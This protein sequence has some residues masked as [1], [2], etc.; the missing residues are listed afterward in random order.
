M[1]NYARVAPATAAAA[2]VCGGEGVEQVGIG[3]V[4]PVLVPRE[5][6]GEHRVPDRHREHRVHGLAL[7]RSATNCAAASRQSANRRKVCACTSCAPVSPAATPTRDG[8]AGSAVPD[9]RVDD[10]VLVARV[11]VRGGEASTQPGEFGRASDSHDHGLRQ[12]VAKEGASVHPTGEIGPHFVEARPSLV[13][14]R[15]EHL[16]RGR[17]QRPGRVG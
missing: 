13:P 15:R 5:R 7:L 10:Y 17:L 4:D 12:E 9:H 6:R 16:N 8:W 11:R 3:V 1:V 2:C 14:D